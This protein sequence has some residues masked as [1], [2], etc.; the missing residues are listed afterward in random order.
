MC[1]I[2]KDNKR[3]WI[4]RAYT[5]LQN[6][7]FSNNRFLAHD[8]SPISNEWMIIKRNGTYIYNCWKCNGSHSTDRCTTK[9][10]YFMKIPHSCKRQTAGGNIFFMKIL[11][12]MQKTTTYIFLSMRLI[13]RIYFWMT[14][15]METAIKITWH[16]T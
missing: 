13:R 1:L 4:A 11:Q 12:E 7:D 5:K 14:L 9:Q 2:K 16:K 3:W 15:M 10:Y 8:T 6:K